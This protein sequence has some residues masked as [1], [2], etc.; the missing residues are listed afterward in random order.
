MFL[1]SKRLD[2][3]HDEYFYVEMEDY[4]SFL[5]SHNSSWKRDDYENTA[6]PEQLARVYLDRS[7][8]ILALGWD[9]E[10]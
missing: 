9:H 10:C 1:A 6:F 4:L 5:R 2:G 8:H 3:I 7:A